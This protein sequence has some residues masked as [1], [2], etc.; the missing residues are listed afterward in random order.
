M[1]TVEDKVVV[2]TG[3]GSGIGRQIA[4]SAARRGAL[5]AISDWDADRLAE[6]V[7]LLEAS[8][9]RELH[10]D[11]RSRTLIGDHYTICKRSTSTDGVWRV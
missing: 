3:A 2:V 9:V 5:L 11:R 7:R 1:R 8:G 6:S 4:L 10:S